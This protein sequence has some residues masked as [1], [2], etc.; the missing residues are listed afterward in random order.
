MVLSKCGKAGGSKRGELNATSTSILFPL[1]LP[2]SCEEE[3]QARFVE[4]QNL[5]N[6]LLSYSY[7]TDSH[8]L[9]NARAKLKLY[10][11]AWGTSRRDE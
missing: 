10:Q 8:Q 2:V 11:V 5:F 9:L 4:P 1:L 6:G 7:H 3:I